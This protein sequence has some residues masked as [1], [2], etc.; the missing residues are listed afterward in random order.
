MVM[1][2]PLLTTGA[3]PHL[4]EEAF[5]FPPHS[6]GEVPSSYEGGGVKRQSKPVKL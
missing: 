4:N 5:D 1:T 2:L 3:P 6:D